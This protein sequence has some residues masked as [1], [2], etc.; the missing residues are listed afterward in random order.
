MEEEGGARHKT[1]FE[2]D[3]S[4]YGKDVPGRP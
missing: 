4:T 2:M 1:S 3:K